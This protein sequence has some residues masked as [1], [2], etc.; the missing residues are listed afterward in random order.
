MRLI[1]SAPVRSPM[2]RIPLPASR[3]RTEGFTRP[4]IDAASASSSSDLAAKN[5]LRGYAQRG[6]P[7]RNLRN[8]GSKAVSD[9]ARWGW[10]I[11]IN[12][13]S[14]GTC[15]WNSESASD[16]EALL[17]ELH[18]TTL[19]SSIHESALVHVAELGSTESHE[20]LVGRWLPRRRTSSRRGPRC[21]NPAILKSRRMS[22][23]PSRNCAASP[24]GIL[25]E[26]GSS[27]SPNAGSKSHKS[28]LRLLTTRL[29]LRQPRG[30]AHLAGFREPRARST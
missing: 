24:L 3:C 22:P 12:L 1:P 26:A 10:A 30:P 13:H 25:Q 17:L 9:R 8:R 4:I 21:K 15:N 20:L 11:L 5:A 23:A 16:F 2:P 7:V 27:P 29:R 14:S 6:S 19:P 28:V 18:L